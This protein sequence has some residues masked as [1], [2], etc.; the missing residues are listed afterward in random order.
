LRK[1][2]LLSSATLTTFISQTITNLFHGLVEFFGNVL[3]HADVRFIGRATF[4]SDAGGFAVFH[5]G[6]TPKN[7]SGL[8]LFKQGFGGRQL[9]YVPTQDYVLSPK[10]HLTSLYEQIL[11]WKR[12]V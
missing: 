7:W 10:Y 1:Y 2:F 3:F 11:N 5:P 6:R 9:D 4:N 8:T 12:G